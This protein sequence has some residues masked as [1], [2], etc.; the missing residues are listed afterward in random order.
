MVRAQKF[1]THISSRNLTPDMP[2]TFRIH[3]S[4]HHWRGELMETYAVASLDYDNPYQT[5]NAFIAF[6]EKFLAIQDITEPSKDIHLQFAEGSVPI[7]LSDEER[8]YYDAV[9]LATSKGWKWEESFNENILTGERKTTG[10]TKP[11]HLSLSTWEWGGKQ[12]GSSVGFPHFQ[13]ENESKTELLLRIL[14]TSEKAKQDF[15]DSIPYMN[16]YGVIEKDDFK[17]RIVFNQYKDG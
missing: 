11:F 16:I 1:F 17:T 5:E 3:A 15:P 7:L 6:K 4:T 8:T 9:Q 13:R 14:E 10:G 2:V 12:L